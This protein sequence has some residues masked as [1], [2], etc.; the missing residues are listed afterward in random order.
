[1]AP[2]KHQKQEVYPVQQKKTSF[3]A[4]QQTM[5]R[6]RGL[7]PND[8]ELV[9]NTYVSLYI[10]NIHTGRIKIINKQN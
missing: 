7:N 4:H 8:W 6:R 2:G 3:T 10:R 5:L 9:K 1:M